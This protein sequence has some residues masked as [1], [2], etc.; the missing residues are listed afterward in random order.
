MSENNLNQYEGGPGG[1]GGPSN[2]N[3]SNGP[4]GPGG[5]GRDPRKQNIIMFVVAALLSLLLVS[6]F[7]KIVTGGSEQE[8]SYNEFIQMLEEEKIQSVIIGTDRIYI[9]SRRKRAA[10]LQFYIYMA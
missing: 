8:V 4:G 6:S 9:Q 2:N 7:V 3:G 5:N 10:R 1:S